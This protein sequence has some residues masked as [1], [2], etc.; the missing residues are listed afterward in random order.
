MPKT[1][2]QELVNLL[3]VLGDPS[4]LSIFDLLM[5]GVQCNCEL[6]DQLKMPMNL[7]SHHLKVLRA[8]GL[9]NAVRDETD[10]RWVYYSVDRQAV[11]QLRGQL[12]GFFDPARIRSRQPSCGPRVISARSI[13]A[14][15]SHMA[16]S[17]AKN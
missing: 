9:V 16:K 8:A 3:K 12:N 10:A 1:G 4:R 7:I 13:A 2:T 5:Q 14:R 15:S 17:L 6:G 11:S